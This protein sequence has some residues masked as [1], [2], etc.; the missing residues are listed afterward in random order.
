MAEAYDPVAWVEEAAKNG[1]LAFEVGTDY[2]DA[3]FVDDARGAGP[4]GDDEAYE[5][6]YWDAAEFEEEPELFQNL[7]I[8]ALEKGAEVRTS[9]RRRG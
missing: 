3:R 9:R 5:L 4:E 7:V 1:T 2:F 8:S 6:I